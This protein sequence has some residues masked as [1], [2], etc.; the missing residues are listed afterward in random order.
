MKARG[1][2]K[3]NK[4]KEEKRGN[5]SGPLSSLSPPEWRSSATPTLVPIH[6]K[7]NI[8]PDL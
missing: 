6:K 7:Q 5:Y 4:T 2:N 1:N 8:F 3:Q